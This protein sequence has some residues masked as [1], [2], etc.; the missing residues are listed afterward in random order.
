MY[1]VPDQ[2]GRTAVVTG[3]NSGTGFHTAKRLAA[4]GATVI[5][6]CRSQ[7]RGERAIDAIRADVPDASLDLRIIDLSSLTSVRAFVRSLTDDL[8][9]LDLLVN[10][11]GV[12]TPPERIETEDGFELQ[13]GSNFFGP[14]ALTVGLLPLLNAAPAPRVATM[15][16]GMANFGRIDFSD[17]NWTSRRYRAEQAYAQSK[18]ADVHLF[19]HLATLARE[20]HWTL[21]SVGAHPGYANTNL[22]TSGANLGRGSTMMKRV[23][24]IGSRF[25]QSA[26]MGAEPLLMAA[27]VPAST[28]QTGG[29]YFG[30]TGL[31]GMRGP[32]GAAKLNRR[33]SDAETAARLWEVAERLTDAHPG[34]SA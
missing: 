9:H 29:D 14:F 21:T 18:L 16:S 4:A 3:A 20:H 26:A 27:T 25:G 2:S 28:L 24:A 8:D 1:A 31:F 30:P 33:M 5:M 6:A 10:N 15:A 13:M 34:S 32:G 17:L 11:A 12:M 19:R 23:T 22:Q 7:T